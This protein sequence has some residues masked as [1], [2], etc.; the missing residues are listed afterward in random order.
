MRFARNNDLRLPGLFMSNVAVAQVT[1]V[2]PK[3][4]IRPVTVITRHVPHIM[5]YMKNQ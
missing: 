5:K 1:A 2:V 3:V 4:S